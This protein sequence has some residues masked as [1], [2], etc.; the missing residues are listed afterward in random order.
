MPGPPAINDKGQIYRY[1]GQNGVLHF[2]GI[3]GGR[4]KVP[5]DI[6]KQLQQQL[7]DRQ[8]QQNQ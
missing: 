4:I 3:A 7:K 2:S 8:N 1:S 5:N 6:K